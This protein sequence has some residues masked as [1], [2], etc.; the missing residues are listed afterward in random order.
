MKKITLFLTSLFL[1]SGLSAQVSFETKELI[2]LSVN[3][4]LEIYDATTYLKNNSA[5]AADTV[6]VWS[7]IDKNA[8]SGWE[9]TV[10]TG[11]ECYS[12]PV[13]SA[14]FNLGLGK[15]MAFKIG[16]GFYEVLGAGEF[17][18]VASSKINP[19]MSD[20]LLFKMRTWGASI[21]KVDNSKFNVY[22]NPA[23]DYTTVKFNSGGKQEVK[24][25]DILGNV[26]IVENVYSGQR[27]DVSSLQSGVYIVRMTGN[28]SYSKVL[29]K[30]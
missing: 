20:T 13:G 4:S 18:V 15:Q 26:Q 3:K 8:E 7:V 22:P 9:L 28:T 5:D 10:C 12:D 25:Y 24:I 21:D 14:E 19:S 11:E 16:Y 6:I 30:K 29:Q 17:K 27:I 1:V 2:N 23:L